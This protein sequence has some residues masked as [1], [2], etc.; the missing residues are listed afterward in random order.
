MTGAVAIANP[1]LV[2]RKAM[3]KTP[4]ARPRSERFGGFGGSAPRGKSA[5]ELCFFQLI[6]PKE[7]R[8]ERPLR[9]FL[10]WLTGEKRG[11]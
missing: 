2:K 11:Y 9:K 3:A 4:A 6:S 5:F 1:A 10:A 7:F 8:R